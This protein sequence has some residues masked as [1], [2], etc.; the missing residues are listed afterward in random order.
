MTT[1]LKD[2][3]DAIS[4]GRFTG[5]DDE[6]ARVYID[7]CDEGLLML[8]AASGSILK[9]HRLGH[10]QTQSVGR[11]RIDRPGLQILIANFWRNTGIVTALDRTPTS[12][13]RKR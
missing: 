1:T 10:A 5:R 7:G 3:A 6:P 11:Y 4:V 13:R 8:D 9:Q 2:H 12:W